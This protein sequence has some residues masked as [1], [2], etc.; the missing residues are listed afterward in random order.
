[1]F[2]L[3]CFSE[4]EKQK[5]NHLCEHEPF[6]HQIASLLRI[7]FLDEEVANSSYPRKVPGRILY[8]F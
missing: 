2:N 6:N 7:P 8:A 1:M 5:F 4:F 3:I